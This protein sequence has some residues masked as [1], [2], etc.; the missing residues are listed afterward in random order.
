[1]SMLMNGR[2]G[3]LAVGHGARHSCHLV[4]PAHTEYSFGGRVC[5]CRVEAGG[6]SLALVD[7]L[8]LARLCLFACCHLVVV[9][10]VLVWRDATRG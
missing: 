9:V 8:L 4:K 5:E 2:L 6:D 7:S 3:G 1:M 10:L